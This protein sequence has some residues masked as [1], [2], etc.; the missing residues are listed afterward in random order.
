[1]LVLPLAFALNGCSFDDSDLQ[2]RLDVVQERIDALQGKIAEANAQIGTLSLLTS[3]NVVTSVGE[4]SDGSYVLT[5][6]DASG[7]EKTMVAAATAQLINVPVIGVR[8]D[9]NG[10]YYWTVTT[11]DETRD[12]TVGG[13]AVP[14]AGKTPVV[15]VDAQ[16]YWTV[17]GVRILDASGSPIEAADGSEAIIKE[18]GKDADGNLA[19]TLGN[20]T[21]VTIPVQNSLNL[22]LSSS[23]KI[24]VANTDAAQTIG[25]ELS[26]S[27][28]ESAIV[29][30]A[31]ADGIKADLDKDAKE[32]T[33][34]FGSDFISGC[35]VVMA[36]DLDK[37]TVLRPV[38][39]DKAD[40]TELH[41]RTSADLV[42]FASRVN[43]QDGAENM[44]VY[45]EN[46][47]D[48]SGVSGWTP[49][50]NGTF[51]GTAVAGASFKGKFY[52]QSHQ[53]TNLVMNVPSDAVSGTVC[54]LFGVL[55]G[56]EVQD[57]TV[58][59]GSSVTSSSSA[60]V[61]AGGV[62]GAVVNSTVSKCS[63]YASFDISG[64][65][66]NISQRFGGIAGSVYSD[67]E[68]AARLESCQNFGKFKSVN[69]VNTK[70]GATAFSEGGVAGFVESASTDLRSIVYACSNYGEMNVQASRNAGVV[71]TLNKNATVEECSN[72][73]AITNT[74]VKASNSR[75]AGI[76]SA[77]GSKTSVL[78]CVNKGDITFAVN[79]DT[80]HG[81]AA[82][83]VGQTNDNSNVVSGCTN[84]GA[85]RSDIINAADAAKRFIAVIVGNTNNKTC[86]ITGNK[87]GGKIGP[88]SDESA[89]VTITADNYSSYIWFTPKTAP[90]KTDGNV[91]AGN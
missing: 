38:F 76:V 65:K 15:S 33:V 39:F 21:R 26:G 3:G 45:L 8:K 82:G 79:G 89:V 9:D 60:L 69:N 73:G 77:M 31:H 53:I 83:I 72:F 11:G 49:I 51:S 40:E 59:A 74:D 68:A 44:E 10:L 48:M 84:L 80:S 16:G 47:I 56:A 91:F 14:V 42:A 24:T 66:D 13:S 4:N 37:V 12:L 17:D 29:A 41:I 81:Y 20:G 7:S 18:I 43:A 55:Y 85:I 71:A 25:Y 90:A 1:M 88:Y 46:D 64:G 5:Y 23:V 78:N 57:V 30:I 75:S 63:S 35:L 2:D 32:I 58:G 34:S 62:A 70:N 22:K 67:G 27:S 87:V 28:A 61:C 36:T 86:T 52:G 54:G 19:I 50:G 6:L